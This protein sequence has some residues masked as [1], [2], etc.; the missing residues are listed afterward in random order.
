MKCIECGGDL[1]HRYAEDLEFNMEKGWVSTAN[2]YCCEKCK[3]EFQIE[4]LAEIRKDSIVTKIKNC[5][6]YGRED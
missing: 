4:L 2:I 3:R 1:M 5:G 6:Y